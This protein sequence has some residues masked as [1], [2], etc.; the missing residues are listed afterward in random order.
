[1]PA[2]IGIEGSERWLTNLKIGWVTLYTLLGTIQSVEWCFSL[3][4]YFEVYVVCICGIQYCT[5][6]ASKNHT[7]QFSNPKYPLQQCE[8]SPFWTSACCWLT[9][10]RSADWKLVLAHR[11][12][13]TTPWHWVR[14]APSP[15]PVSAS[16]NRTAR[17]CWSVNGPYYWEKLPK[18][19]EGR[20]GWIQQ[21]NLQTMKLSSS[22]VVFVCS[23]LPK[24]FSLT[25]QQRLLHLWP[26]CVN[27][28]Q[29]S[30]LLFFFPKWLSPVGLLQ[31]NSL[32]NC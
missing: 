11:P 30:G 27:E 8:A 21:R 31:L 6:G 17:V 15:C 26:G 32:C 12:V 3:W 25:D 5:T 16:G 18:Q 9:M 19:A 4:P 2:E 13:A 24:P 28:F 1:M 22:Q 29:K 10:N 14:A 20:A 23:G 7:V